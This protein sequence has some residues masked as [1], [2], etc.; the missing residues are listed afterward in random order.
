[1]LEGAG[2]SEEDPPELY[3]LGITFDHAA[4][5]MRHHSAQ[6]LAV[7]V[8][9]FILAERVVRALDPVDEAVAGFELYGE[10]LTIEVV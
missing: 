9:L 3:E 4:E 10:Q 7:V 6:R 1:M 2:V 5:R 8:D